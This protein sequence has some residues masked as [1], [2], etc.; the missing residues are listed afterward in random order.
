MNR[1]YVALLALLVTHAAQATDV[2]VCTDRGRFV[3]E[4]ADS[5]A[6]KHV[7]NF[8]RYVDMAYYSG[9]VFHRVV[10]GFVVQGGGYDRDLRNRPALPPIQNES[11]NGLRNVRGSV[12]AARTEDPDS[13]TSQF[14]VNL[15]D[16]TQV[17]HFHD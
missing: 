6:P 5:E 8:L 7:E 9:T 1:S 4:L 2:A 17:V 15:K 10:S 16:N 14:Y 13:A 11:R 12:A 3:I